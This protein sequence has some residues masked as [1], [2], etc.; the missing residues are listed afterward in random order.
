MRSDFRDSVVLAG[1]SIA[2]ALSSAGCSS[3]SS[4]NRDEDHIDVYGYVSADRTVFSSVEPAGPAADGGVLSSEELELL[5]PYTYFPANRIITFHVGLL[6]TPTAINP[7]LSF[8]A[9][10]NHTVAP[11]AGNQSLIRSYNKDEIVLRNDTCTEF[12]VWLTASTSA[13]PFHQV[14]DAG[15]EG[16]ASG[17]DPA[18]TAGASGAP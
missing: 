9:E 8:F 16:G 3:I 17:A 1:V 2:L 18:E 5:P 15:A 7:Y 4:C 12:W 11:A 13:M 10:R 6:D 14:T